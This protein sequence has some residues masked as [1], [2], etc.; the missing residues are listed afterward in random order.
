M[1]KTVQLYKAL[2]EE[3]RLRILMLLTHNELCVCDLMAIFD[4]P[5]SKISRHLA[6]LRHSGLVRSERVGTWM[7]Y[8]IREPLDDTARAQLDFMYTHLASLDWSKDD[9]KKMEKVKALKLCETTT[10]GPDGMPAGNG[11][12][13]KRGKDTGR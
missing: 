3:I 6:Y 7:H 1:E 5:Q 11:P 10:P 9:V 12:A 4:E 2:S 13:R 8:S